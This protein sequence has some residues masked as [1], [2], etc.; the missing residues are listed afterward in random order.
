MWVTSILP[1]H[2]LPVKHNLRDEYGTGRTV[3][4]TATY[5][6]NLSYAAS[7]GLITKHGAF[8]IQHNTAVMTHMRHK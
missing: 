3:I 4:F 6:K 2:P 1:F 7:A 8:R 5:Q